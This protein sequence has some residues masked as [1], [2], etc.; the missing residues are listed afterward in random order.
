MSPPLA[1]SPIE[2][3]RKNDEPALKPRVQR[4]VQVCKMLT[5]FVLV[6]LGA[7]ILQEILQEVSSTTYLAEFSRVSGMAAN[8]IDVNKN[9]DDLLITLFALIITFVLSVPVAWVHSL[10]KT[11]APDPSLTQTLVVLSV[12]VAGV[13]LLLEDNLAR[14]FSLVGVVAAVRY[15]NNLID[16][17]DAAYVFLSLALGMAC[18]LQAYHVG[19][20]LCFFACAILLVL[21]VFHAGAPTVGEGQLVELL[22]GNEKKG[23][24]TPAEAMAWLTADARERVEAELELQSRYIMLAAQHQSKGGKRPNCVVTVKTTG[25]P[26]AINEHLDDHRGKWELLDSRGDENGV[27]TLD[28]L[29]RL[30]KKHTPPA[31]LLERLRSCDP[32]VTHVEFR[33]LRKM[34][35]EKANPDLPEGDLSSPAEPGTSPADVRSTH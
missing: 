20:L 8:I 33:S 18:G 3:Q 17:K 7:R 10:T 6:G 5:Y 13:M 1:P 16:P 23:K 31:K 28:Y 34:V 25:S 35:P 14:A 2:L 24:R 12:I 30:G 22:K 21:W 19:L 11:S 15:R 29:G 9:A 27:T 4:I 26:D 32:G